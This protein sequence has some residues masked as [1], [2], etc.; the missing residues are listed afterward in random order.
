MVWIL[1]FCKPNFWALVMASRSS[2][3][4]DFSSLDHIEIP[5]TYP[6]LQCNQE[7]WDSLDKCG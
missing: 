1:D 2:A 4:S 3:C 6:Q 5:M 7:N